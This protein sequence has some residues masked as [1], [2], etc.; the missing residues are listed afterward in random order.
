M[1]KLTY[2][3]PVYREYIADPFVLR[4]G[5]RY[6]AYGTAPADGRGNQFPILTSTNLVQWTYVRHALRAAT[7]FAHWA[8]EV[9]RGDDGKFYL[10]HSASDVAGDEGHRLRVAIADS[11]EGPFE[12]S[13]TLLVPEVGFSI[14][15]HPF[16]DAKS[17]KW[18]VYF[19]ADF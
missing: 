7:P 12:D 8:P 4:V 14:D 5:D 19:A 18:F 6:F 16:R 13:R 3:N 9:A 15:A 17:G 11:P 10:Y 1:A 2:R